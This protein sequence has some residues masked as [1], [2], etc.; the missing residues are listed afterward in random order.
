MNLY[1]P[2]L[3]HSQ[4]NAINP[5][6]GPVP[7]PPAVQNSKSD[8]TPRF[9]VGY[10]LPVPSILVN[11]YNQAAPEERSVPSPPLSPKIAPVSYNGPKVTLPSI[12][13]LISKHPLDEE[14]AIR[15]RQ[16]W[17]VGMTVKDYTG[18]N[19]RFLSEYSVFKDRS[20]RYPQ[21]YTSPHSYYHG[22]LPPVCYGNAMNDA[23]HARFRSPKRILDSQFNRERAFNRTNRKYTAVVRDNNS[24]SYT[25]PPTYT[26]NNS[27][28]VYGGG[29]QQISSSPARPHIQQQ[30][31]KRQHAK[32]AGQNSSSTANRRFERKANPATIPPLASAAIV[33]KAPQYVPQISWQQLPDYS[34]PLSTIP[35]NKYCMKIEWK[36]SQMDLSNDPLRDQ[37]HPAELVL[38]QILRL[39]CDLYLDSKRRFFL[40]KVYRVKN[41]K[42]FRRTDAQK[43][44][45]I[46]VNKASRLFQAF[47]KIGWLDDKYF[48][49]VV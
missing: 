44:C 36:G 46:D 14:E 19:M 41:G 7:H 23:N 21:T 43:A 3:E 42:T 26:T 40:E 48:K 15:V 10:G 9:G 1:S 5:R 38:A 37:L 16:S 31:H 22:S 33:S 25:S 17:P 6:L 32:T 20:P 29:Y 49:G 24:Y 12:A 8:V 45:R 34:P 4:L 18:N 30:Q 39:P 35:D 2:Q 11:S 47:E 28:Y 27:S 13:G